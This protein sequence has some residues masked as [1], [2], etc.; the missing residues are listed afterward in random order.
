MGGFGLVFAA[1]V[2]HDQRLRRFCLLLDTGWSCLV[3]ADSPKAGSKESR[4][5]PEGDHDGFVPCVDFGHN[6]IRYS[7]NC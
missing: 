2:T 3:A 7:M 6:Y 5:A 4:G 1:V